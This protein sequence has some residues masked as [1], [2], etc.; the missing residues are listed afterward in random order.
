MLIPCPTTKACPLQL[1]I[2]SLRTGAAYVP[3]RAASRLLER[4]CSNASAG[5]ASP[6]VQGGVCSAGWVASAVRR[7]HSSAASGSA[8]AKPLWSAAVRTLHQSSASHCAFS[9][10][11]CCRASAHHARS[12]SN[13]AALQR[14]LWPAAAR[15]ISTASRAA[16]GRVP[17]NPWLAATRA[18]PARP[19]GQARSSTFRGSGA[20][21]TRCVPALDPVFVAAACLCCTCRLH[22]PAQH[23]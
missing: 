13:A 12:A 3:M 18:T 16:A 19:A 17:G 5:A 20:L 8:V 4:L 22:I 21:Q 7:H 1:S 6:A 11:V 2:S 23:H 14:C 15:A 9:A 10:A